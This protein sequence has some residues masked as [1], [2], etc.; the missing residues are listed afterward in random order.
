MSE[1]SKLKLHP[2]NKHNKSYNFDALI[3][4]T[5]QLA[6]YVTVNKYGVRTLDFFNAEAV[7]LLNQSLLNSD[8]N[9][10][11]WDIPKGY[12]C[13]PIPG[14]ADY[15]HYLAD[16]LAAE[17]KG[18]IPRGANTKILD[19]GTG[20]NCIYPILGALEYDWDFVGCDVDD[21]A[22]K[23]ANAI[24]NA[25]PSLTKKI[26]ILKQQNPQKIF[27]TIIQPTDKFAATI[28]NPPFHASEQ[29]VISSNLKKLKKLTGKKHTELQL[30][31]GGQHNEL[32]YPGGELAF[33]KKMIIESAHFA[34]Q[35]GWFTTLVSKGG[36]VTELQKV[37]TR[38]KAK[39][40]KT[41]EM[42]QGNK[43]SR[44]VAWRF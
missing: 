10:E 13:P 11:F 1:A 9:I 5:P 23:V 6:N 20:A 42:G 8:Y 2:R 35:V 3:A 34:N 16:L 32:W 15:I 33:I 22:V 17:N 37:L 31:F 7:K 24:I 30:S 27:D 39:E 25:N 21:K 12:L 29:E 18:D 26:S 36:N 4:Q 28:C 41:I 14:R 40:V 43:I 44:F 38:I 19:I